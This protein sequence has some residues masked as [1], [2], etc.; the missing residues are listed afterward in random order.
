M[1]RVL[2]FL[3]AEDLTA[4][5]PVC[6]HFRTAVAGNILW[7]RLFVARCGVP[8]RMPDFTAK[9]LPW[10]PIIT[11]VARQT[12]VL[13]SRCCCHLIRSCYERGIDRQHVPMLLLGPCRWGNL[14]EDLEAV[15]EWERP[16]TW[17]VAIIPFRYMLLFNQL[18]AE[19]GGSLRM[20]MFG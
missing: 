14:R 10:I 12:D 18:P 3:S 1:F 6:R 8:D 5:A 4:A 11:M 16:P 20:W 17:K 9:S 15:K 2:S 19:S 13:P 7:K